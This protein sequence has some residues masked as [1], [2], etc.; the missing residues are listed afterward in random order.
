VRLRDKGDNKFTKG[1]PARWKA[2]THQL[3]ANLQEYE[4]LGNYVIVIKYE[5]GSV[6]YICDG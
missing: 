6:D 5:D 1:R 3:G 2:M 4:N